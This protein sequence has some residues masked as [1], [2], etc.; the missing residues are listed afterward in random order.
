[1]AKLN[2]TTVTIGPVS[3]ALFDP[4]A[5]LIPRLFHFFTVEER[6]SSLKYLT[7]QLKQSEN[8]NK[9]IIGIT[10]YPLICSY[11]CVKHCIP[12]P[13]RNETMPLYANLKQHYSLML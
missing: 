6:N 13:N 9:I 3:L 8:N 10:H 5:A 12:D 7:E 4:F 2:A 11:P 1:L